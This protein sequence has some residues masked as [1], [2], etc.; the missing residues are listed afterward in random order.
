MGSG[1]SSIGRRL[2]DRFGLAFIDADQQI[3]SRTGT[4]IRTIFECEGEAGFRERERATLAELL[5]A[6]STLIATGGGAVVDPVTRSLLQER[7]FVVYL[8]V[9]IAQQLARLA[10][11]RS[12]PLL[13]TDDRESVL[14]RLAAEREPLYVEVA[15][16]CFDTDSL[17]AIDTTVKLGRLLEQQWRPGCQQTHQHNETTA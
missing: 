6:S 16:L 5:S 8:K 14:R 3:E 12:R 10:R 17:G 1:K 11:D 2:A 15:D 9:G 7:G 13:A 4:S